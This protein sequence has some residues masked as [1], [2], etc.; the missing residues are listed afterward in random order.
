M[1]S[2]YSQWAEDAVPVPFSAVLQGGAE[3][4]YVFG[5]REYAGIAGNTTIHDTGE[6]IVYLSAEDAAIGLLLGR[7]D[8]A[9]PVTFGRGCPMGICC[10]DPF[11]ILIALAGEIV[12]MGHT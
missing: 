12:G 6:W 2:F 8:E 9:M 5:T 10:I 3:D 7:S 1:H 11:P 4:S